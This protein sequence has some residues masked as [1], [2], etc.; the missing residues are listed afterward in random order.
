[1]SQLRELCD[2]CFYPPPTS[3]TTSKRSP[4]RSSG[5]G[6]ACAGD[7][8]EIQLDGHVRLRDAQLAEKFGD[9]H[10]RLSIPRGCPF[11]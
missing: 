3:V 6:V 7:D 5:F 2:S 9:A 11:T 10:C 4:S 1:M 8:F